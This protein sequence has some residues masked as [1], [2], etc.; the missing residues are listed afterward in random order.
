MQAQHETALT[1]AAFKMRHERNR[2]EQKRLEC[3]STVD[4]VIHEKNAENAAKVQD[5]PFTRKV[6]LLL[7]AGVIALKLSRD[8]VKRALFARAYALEKE[9]KKQEIVRPRASA[10][11]TRTAADSE[12]RDSGSRAAGL[13]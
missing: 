7:Q 1:E 6:S 10:T 9:R 11:A 2:F 3:A 4:R 5:M 13:P 12:H 8:P